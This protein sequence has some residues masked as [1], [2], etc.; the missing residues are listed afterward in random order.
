MKLEVP[1]KFEDVAVEFSREEWNMLNKEEKLLHREVMMENF[2]NM[3]SLGYNIP[4][5]KLLLLVKEPDT[6]SVSAVEDENRLQTDILELS[7]TSM[8]QMEFSEDA[9]TGIKAMYQSSSM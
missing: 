7:Q 1:E 3:V 5:Q 8:T 2:E 6:H 4:V 9:I